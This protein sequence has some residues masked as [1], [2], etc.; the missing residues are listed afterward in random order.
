MI[1]RYGLNYLDNIVLCADIE[2][3]WFEFKENFLSYESFA[4]H[5]LVYNFMKY[6]NNDFYRL[7]KLYKRDSECLLE[8]YCKYISDLISIYP[9]NNYVYKN[10]VLPFYNI[11]TSTRP[12]KKTISSNNIIQEL[13]TNI[14]VNLVLNE[15]KKQ[16][17]TRE[18]VEMTSLFHN[19]CRFQYQRSKKIEKTR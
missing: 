17:F 10:E 6:I 4:Y 12:Y 15:I 5:N 8:Y 14:A 11:L 13:C 18:E 7:T 19:Y 1:D 3:L 2:L 9:S 16:K